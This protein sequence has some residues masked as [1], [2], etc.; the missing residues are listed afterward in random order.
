MSAK[1]LIIGGSFFLILL[2]LV[3]AYVLFF[4]QPQPPVSCNSNIR[5]G[6]TTLSFAS[7]PKVFCD[8]SPPRVANRDDYR[9]SLEPFLQESKADADQDPRLSGLAVVSKLINVRQP[10]VDVSKSRIHVDKIAL[11]T[12]KDHTS[13]SCGDLALNAQNAG[14]SVVTYF[15]DGYCGPDGNVS[16]PHTQEEILIPIVFVGNC[17][18]CTSSHN[19]SWFNQYEFF[20]ATDKTFVNIIETQQGSDELSKMT[21][22]RKRLYY[23]FL[24]GPIITLEWLRRKKKLCC[25]T[26]SHQVDEESAAGNEENVR[27]VQRVDE[28]QEQDI[29]DITGE[30][31]ESESQP[32]INTMYTDTDITTFDHMGRIIVCVTRLFGRSIRYLAVGLGYVLLSLVALPVGIS[33]GGLSFFRF[34]SRVPV[35]FLGIL[36][37]WWPSIQIFCFFMYSRFNCASA[38]TVL[39]NVSKLIRSHWFSSNMY[40]LVLCFVVPYCSLSQRLFSDRFTFSTFLYLTVYNVTCTVCNFLFIIILNKHKVVTRYVFY[41]SVCMIC[42]YVESDIVAVFYF[43]LNSQ[44]SLNNLKLTALRTVALGLT[45]TL[46]FSSSMHIIHKLMKPQESVFEGLSEK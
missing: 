5:S 13:F 26:I 43:I 32:L 11:V 16:K 46:S 20:K 44:G 35:S 38:W 9:P 37:L 40:L 4:L 8:L 17:I 3:S 31:I 23:W 25:V 41:I 39:T 33:G 18:N 28:D 22:Y 34:D 42:A 36:T 30:E 15:G 12:L 45:L 14:Y 7:V 2:N 21:K 24:L 1:F 10:L 6:T 29:Q 19:S 27:L